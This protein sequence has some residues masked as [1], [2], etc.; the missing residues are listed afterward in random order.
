[1]RKRNSVKKL[2]RTD[3][4]RKALYAN[5]L[6]ILFS[7]GKLET[8]TVKAKA[9][10][11]VASKLLNKALN[12]KNVMNLA[13]SLSTEL[14]TAE[15]R[16][17][18]VEYATKVGTRISIVRVG[19]RAGDNAQKAE[20]TLPDFDKVVVKKAKAEKKPKKV[21]A[22]KTEAAAKVEV[23]KAEVKPEIAKEQVNKGGF[24]Q[25]L[26]QTFTGGS[27]ERARSRSGL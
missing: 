16:K 25:K 10:K 9:M 11:R 21:E 3:S 6:S 22:K 17:L 20:L 8:T 15:S 14:K 2:G 1:M 13:K 27:K 23:A 4:H 24:A 18:L 26:K 7:T 12:S 5:Q 19:Y